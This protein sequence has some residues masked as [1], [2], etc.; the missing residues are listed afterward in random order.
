MEPP[1]VAGLAAA[2]GLTRSGE[3]KPFTA[4]KSSPVNAHALCSFP[5]DPAS[6]VNSSGRGFLRSRFRTKTEML[7]LARSSVAATSKWG[8]APIPETS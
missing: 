7:P 5:G 4:F 3:S 1:D 8:T 6:Q 2:S